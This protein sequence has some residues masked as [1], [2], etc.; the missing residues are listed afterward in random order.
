[1]KGWLIELHVT[2]EDP[3]A[4]DILATARELALEHDGRVIGAFVDPRPIDELAE[5]AY[6]RRQPNRE[7]AT[8]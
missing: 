4:G 5:R 7:G 6:R 2:G 3:L 1:V 8:P